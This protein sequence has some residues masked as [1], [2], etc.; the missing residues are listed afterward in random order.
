MEK[1]ISFAVMIFFDVFQIFVFSPSFFLLLILSILLSGEIS[2]E[3]GFH[4][5][6]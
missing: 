4:L 6:L 5:L 2:V 3:Q 1:M